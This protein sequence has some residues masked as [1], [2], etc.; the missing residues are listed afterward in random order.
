MDVADFRFNILYSYSDALKGM[1][2]HL[3]DVLRLRTNKK[4]KL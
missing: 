1:F 4:A 2:P 3:I